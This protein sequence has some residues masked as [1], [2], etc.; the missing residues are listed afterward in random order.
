[1]LAWAPLAFGAAGDHEKSEFAV[2]DP[3][4][5]TVQSEPLTLD[6]AVALA[7]ERAPDL[8]AR[9]A[10]LDAAQSLTTSAGRLPD[11]ELVLAL[12]NLPVEGDDA[13]STT[14]DFMTMRRIG[15]MQEFPRGAK[16][17]L[18]H[19]YAEAQSEL[20]GAE[21]EEARLTVAREVAEAWIR[22]AT[23][24]ST[25]A[26]LRTLAPELEL[27]ASAAQA[28]LTAGRESAAQALAA[29]TA[30][31]RLQNRLTAVE[32]EARRAS[33]D[34]ERWLHADAERPLA[35]MP[36]LD[37]LP[38][39]AASLVASIREHS[40][41]QP[42]DARVDAARLDIE[43]AKAERRP[44]WSAELG[45]SK[46]GPDY[47]DMVSLEFRIG[48]ALNTRNRQKPVI[49]AKS[50]E[51]RRLE[52]DRDAEIRMHLAELQQTLTDWELLGR[53]LERYDAELLPLA[54]DRT[55]AALATYRA[56]GGDLRLALESFE[57][58]IETRIEHASLTSERGRAWAY[59]R[60][61]VPQHLEHRQPEK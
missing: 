9:Q 53:T 51:L 30:V 28:A 37:A 3:Q 47:S 23:A 25:L 8:Q 20:A 57:Q 55:R 40:S 6:A 26:E 38:T 5:P 45:Y 21:L 33:L 24:E 15:V 46:R 14:R 41:L 35:P 59:L 7:I 18:R 29:Q 12:D 58:E 44:D 10:G 1:L 4:P 52:A 61:V 17:R 42:Y 16:R 54:R 50:A 39:P 2:A 34:L 60:Y 32:G 27:Q 13:Y 11:P 48:L 36:A 31:V 19:D 22:R 49:A 56:G 43:L